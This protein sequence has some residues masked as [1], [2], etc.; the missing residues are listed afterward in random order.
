M[1]HRRRIQIKRIGSTDDFTGAHRCLPAKLSSANKRKRNR[2]KDGKH[3]EQHRHIK[4]WRSSS[5][6]I[7]LLHLTLNLSTR[8]ASPFVF[9]QK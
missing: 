2:Q 3:P 9:S 6:N 1:A 7:F 8:R 4:Y 5:A